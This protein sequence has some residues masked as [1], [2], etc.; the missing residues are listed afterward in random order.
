MSVVRY[1]AISR[2][3]GKNFFFPG[4]WG[5]MKG[6]LIYN[7]LRKCIYVKNCAVIDI[8]TGENEF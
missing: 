6:C 7:V 1:V 4:G 5:E 3:G 8:R 2:G